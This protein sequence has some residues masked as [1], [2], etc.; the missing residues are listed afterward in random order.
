MLIIRK[1]LLGALKEL[2]P[3]ISITFQKLLKIMQHCCLESWFINDHTT[4]N[5]E[6]ESLVPVYYMYVA[7]FNFCILSI[8]IIFCVLMYLLFLYV[9]MYVTRK[10]KGNEEKW[11]V[12]KDNKINK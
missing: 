4:I 7:C 6:M 9:R 3:F 8:N 5:R 10:F 1:F 2:L 12:V 11:K